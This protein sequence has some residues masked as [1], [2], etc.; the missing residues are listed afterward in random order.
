MI[1]HSRAILFCGGIDSSNTWYDLYK[2]SIDTTA[3]EEENEK[4]EKEFFSE[5]EFKV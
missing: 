4:E 5:E 3:G 2:K 1:L